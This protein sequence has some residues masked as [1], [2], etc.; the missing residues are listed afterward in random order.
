MVIIDECGRAMPLDLLIPMVR[1]KSLVLVG[2]H[3][4]LPPTLDPEM[5]D[6][7]R[8]Q[9]LNDPAISQSLFEKIITSAHS[10]R[11]EAMELQ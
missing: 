4:Q 6:L 11:T 5:E 3:R 7:L 2:D 10:S 1:G 9:G 8:E